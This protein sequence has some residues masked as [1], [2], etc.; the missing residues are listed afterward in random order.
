MCFPFHRWGRWQSYA[1]KYWPLGKKGFATQT[2]QFRECANCGLRADRFV[3]DWLLPDVS[4]TYNTV[5]K[6]TAPLG[7]DD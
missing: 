5:D 4:V 6:K 1:M 2:R 7:L 3:T